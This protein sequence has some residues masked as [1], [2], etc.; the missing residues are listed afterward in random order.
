MSQKKVFEVKCND[1]GKATTVPFEPAKGKPV[2]CRACFSKRRGNQTR[3][4]SASIQF[5]MKN[6]WAIRGD[7]KQ[8]TKK[9]QS[10]FQRT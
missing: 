2:Y 10:V 8:K 9:R 3:T 7:K 6:A 5:D 4:A 1:C